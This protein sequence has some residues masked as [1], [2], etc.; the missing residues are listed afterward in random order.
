[1]QELLR[2]YILTIIDESDQCLGQFS[3]KIS[4]DYQRIKGI[5]VIL[6]INLQSFKRYFKTQDFYLF[7]KIL[8]NICIS[9]IHVSETFK[10]SI[11]ITLILM[12]RIYYI[13]IIV[14]KL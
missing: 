4:E 12:D 5:N 11:L 2:S 10:I 13:K 14:S 1:M 6:P 9:D 8:N 7:S 3:L